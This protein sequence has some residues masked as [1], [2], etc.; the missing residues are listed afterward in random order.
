MNRVRV[1]TLVAASQERH[2]R[3]REVAVGVDE[4]GQEPGAAA[5]RNT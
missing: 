4:T 3:L 2:M 5:R 1:T